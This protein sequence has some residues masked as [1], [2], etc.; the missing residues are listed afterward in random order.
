MSVSYTHL[1][2]IWFLGLQGSY[3]RGEAGDQSDIDVVIIL[4]TVSASD[5]ETYAMLLEADEYNAKLI[6]D[7]TIY[8]VRCT[9]EITSTVN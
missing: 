4:D 1:D 3:G 8:D 5:L 7:L 9:I 2:R 6:Y